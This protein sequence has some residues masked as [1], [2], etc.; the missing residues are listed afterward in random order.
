MW[1]S[2]TDR[3]MAILYS[4]KIIFLV[5]ERF[6]SICTI[7]LCIVSQGHYI[8]SNIELTEGVKVKKFNFFCDDYSL[9]YSTTH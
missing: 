7:N 3:G 6:R 5:V 4:F 9:K 2:S 1:Y 8:F